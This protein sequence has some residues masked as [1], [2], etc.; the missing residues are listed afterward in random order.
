M[1][2]ELDQKDMYVHKLVNTGKEGDICFWKPVVSDF[3]NE[4]QLQVHGQIEQGVWLL[5]VL[6]R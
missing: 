4:N 1:K 5:Y 2:I 3:P 6:K